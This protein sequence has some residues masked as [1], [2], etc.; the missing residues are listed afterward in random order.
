MSGDGFLPR[1]RG[2]REA[3]FVGWRGG[4][5]LFLVGVDVRETQDEN[6]DHG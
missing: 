6:D 3:C 2:P 1:I 4:G 5:D